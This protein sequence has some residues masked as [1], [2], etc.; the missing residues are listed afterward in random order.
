LLIYIG[1]AILAQLLLGIGYAWLQRA[2]VPVPAAP[3]A[4]R[5]A[6]ASPG[7]WG[8]LRPFRV[9]KRHY[10]DAAQT[11]CSFYLEP[12]DGVALPPFKPGQ[13]LTFSLSLPAQAPDAARSITRCYSLSDS[14]VASHYRVTIK[15]VPAPAEPPGL[16]PGASSNYF[17]DHVHTGDT[18]QVRAP[19]GHFHLDAA[20]ETPVVLIA[21]GIGITP[22][23]SMLRW[24][25][26]HQP[27]RAV[28]L[29][30]G[31]RN[32]AEQAYKA[33]LE[34]LAATLAPF[35]LHMVYSRPLPDDAKPRDYQHAG[36]INLDLLKSTLPHG[37]HQFYLCGP[38]ALLESVV[39]ALVQWGVAPA[40]IHF[41][42]FGPSTVRLPTPEATEPVALPGDPLQIH[43]TKSGRSLPWTG[44]ESNLLDF[45]EAHGIVVESG[46][47]SGSCGSCVT[48]LASGTVDYANPPDF[49][50]A[51]GQCLLCVAKPRAPLTLDA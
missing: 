10:E 43:F 13:F 4:T 30:Y 17:H 16:L 39:P 42:A 31:V 25:A 49:D 2:P 34:E 36:H 48:T 1:I 12:V 35:K 28:H 15:R 50:I 21:G 5:P 23:L 33:V 18:L 9:V 14:P 7:A 27:G 46:C 47:R 45:A 8:G 20:A 6:A 41:E 32:S 29:Y 40:D 24:C 3:A 37:P 44:R 19:A 11:Q 22:M 26:Q 51:P 38:S